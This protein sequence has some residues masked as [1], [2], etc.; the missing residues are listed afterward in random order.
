[1]MVGTPF[2]EDIWDEVETWSRD[3][4]TAH[5]LERMKKQLNWPFGSWKRLDYFLC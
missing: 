3:R 1:M 5:Q 4:I 2:S